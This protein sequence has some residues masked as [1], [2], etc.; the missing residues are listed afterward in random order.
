M[1][2]DECLKETINSS[3]EDLLERMKTMSQEDRMSVMFE[4]MEFLC[5]TDNEILMVPNFK[6]QEERNR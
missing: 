1:N 2:Y 4:W 5:F 3:V 6:Q